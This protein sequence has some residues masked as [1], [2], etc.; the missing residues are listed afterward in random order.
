M[1][2][3]FHTKRRLSNVPLFK[4]NS[5]YHLSF[6]F[7]HLKKKCWFDSC[8]CKC[9]SFIHLLIYSLT[10]IFIYLFLFCP[11]RKVGF[12]S[13]FASDGAE[14]T[15]REGNVRK[16]SWLKDSFCNSGEFWQC[17]GFALYILAEVRTPTEC[18]HTHTHTLG[19]KYTHTDTRKYILCS[20]SF[21][22]SLQL[23]LSICLPFHFSLFS[24]SV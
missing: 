7:L 20:L 13:C 18:T 8:F 24:I 22:P 1:H 10:Y 6:L 11:W 5:I 3:G 21:S 14:P 4:I 15:R 2:Y 12:D 17:D 19:V 9:I 23:S 16:M